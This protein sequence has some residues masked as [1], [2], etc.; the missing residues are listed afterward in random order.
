MITNIVDGRTNRYRWKKV[1]VIVEATWH[2]NSVAGSDQATV[3]DEAVDYAELDDMSLAEAIAWAQ[4]QPG[5]ITLF[6]YDAPIVPINSS[7]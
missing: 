4:E 2:D 7:P 3:G 1:H 6:I 5:E